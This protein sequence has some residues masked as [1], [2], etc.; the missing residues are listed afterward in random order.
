MVFQLVYSSRAAAPIGR[1]ALMALLEDVRRRNTERGVTGMLLYRDGRF[2][3]LLEDAEDDLADAEAAAE[4]AE[5]ALEN[6]LRDIDADLVKLDRSE[7]GS[8]ARMTVFPHGFGLEIDPDGRAHERG[9]RCP[10]ERDR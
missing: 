8:T 3:Q 1:T 6:A 2:L 7:I 10:V 5:E 9:A 4:A